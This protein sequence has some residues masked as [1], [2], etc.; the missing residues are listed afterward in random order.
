[1][2]IEWINSIPKTINENGCWIPELVPNNTSGYVLISIKGKKFVLSRLSMCIYNN[3]DY[4][5]S[6]IDT[7]HSSICT[8]SCFNPKHLKPGS[9]S[10]N[11]YDA[12]KDKKDRNSKKDYCPKCGGEYST[13]TN[14]TGIFRSK[15]SRECL[16]C[17][18]EYRKLWRE[19]RRKRG[20][21]AT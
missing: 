13:R 12:V 7:R 21:K 1:M 8:K 3:I 19:N 11:R 14:K 4:S 6:K 17:K 20:L 15:I 9:A 18:E 2:T 5:N 10:D 16:N